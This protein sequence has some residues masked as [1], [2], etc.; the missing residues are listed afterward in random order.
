MQAIMLSHLLAAAAALP[1]P[2]AAACTPA[3]PCPA[4]PACLP[5]SSTLVHPCAI[6]TASRRAQHA[7]DP[8]SCGAPAVHPGARQQVGMR[9]AGV[10]GQ[11]LDMPGRPRLSVWQAHEVA[12]APAERCCDVLSQLSLPSNFS[13]C[14]PSCHQNIL[15][16]HLASCFLAA[17]PRRHWRAT[18]GRSLRGCSPRCLGLPANL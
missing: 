9:A 17:R 11:G 3:A 16:C 10:Y 14:V 7:D 4:C 2:A 1:W 6:L 13:V 18:C 15:L 5:A 12:G 8:C